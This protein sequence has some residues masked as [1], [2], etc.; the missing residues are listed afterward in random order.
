L[1]D[2]MISGYDISQWAGNYVYEAQGDGGI[3]IFDATQTGGPVEQGL[4]Y[5]GPHLTVTAYDLLS[6][7]PYL[8]AA[9]TS[10]VDGAVLSVYDTSTNPI[11]RIGEYVD[12]S[13][14]GFSVQSSGSYVYF[15]MGTNMAVLNVSQPSSP[16][17]VTSLPL[18]AASLARVNS[19]L[20]AGTG[21][22][23]LV[24]MDISN[25]A[26]PTITSSIPLP[27]SPLKLRVS[28]NLLLVA[29][30]LSGLFIYDI[31]SPSSPVPVSQSTVFAAVNDVL[32]NGTTAFVAADVDGL[33]ILDIS[34]P[35][36]P[37]LVS[38]TSLGRIDP[39]SNLN[40]LNEASSIALNNGVVYVG[41]VGD[42]GLVFGL[43]CANPAVPRIVSK[44]AYGTSILTSVY[45]LLFTGNELLVA[46]ALNSGVYPISQVDVSQP[47]DSINEYFPPLALQA[48]APLGAAQ[49]AKAN[50][51]FTPAASAFYQVAG[52]ENPPH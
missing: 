10:N 13:Q 50:S 40:P 44:Y 16:S 2:G 49:Q 35:A 41:T 19:T 32:V 25:A 34:N 26:Q 28:N 22:N 46:G 36:H 52:P 6:Q 30:G 8:Y 15:G 4:L 24:V 43:D 18:P 33:G 23:S 39:F 1:F 12:K 14:P 9:T 21:N 29:D 51:V 3:A 7:P 17:L 48:P 47:F 38:K 31:T 20:F 37:V 42:N 11:T 45:S 27:V 5:G